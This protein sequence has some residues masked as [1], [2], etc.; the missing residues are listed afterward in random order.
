[1][2]MPDNFYQFCDSQNQEDFVRSREYILNHFDYEPYSQDLHKL[3]G[4]FNKGEY[5]KVIDFE[6]INILLSPRAN[7]IKGPACM[8]MD[9]VDLAI[10]YDTKGIKILEGILRS[11]KNSFNS[12]L[13]ILRVEDERDVINFLEDELDQQRLKST[14]NRDL[15]IIKCKSGKE[16]VFDVSLILKKQ[17]E[18]YDF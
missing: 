1:M 17:G 15:D 3:D 7:F 9:K 2:T 11:G 12:P 16:Y 6:S 8:K 14:F 13:Q 5:D 10:E 18:Q 4:Y